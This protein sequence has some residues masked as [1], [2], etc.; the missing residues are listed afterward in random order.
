MLIMNLLTYIESID[1][2]IFLYINHDMVNPFFD[3]VFSS[4][5]VLTYVFWF[6]LVVYFWVRKE[7]KL[8][9]LLVIGIIVGAIIT[10]SIKYSIDRAR[11]YDQITSTRIVTPLE[12]DPSFPSEHA[13]MSF[14]A[15]TIISRFHPIYGKYL[16]AFSCIVGLSRIYVGVHFPLDVIG[17]AIVGIIVGRLMLWFFKSRLPQLFPAL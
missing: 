14:F 4:L 8:A 5:R 1:R 2:S 12:I 9:L 10:Y 6:L 13:E 15:A 11:P 17:G 7:K 3:A 16:Y